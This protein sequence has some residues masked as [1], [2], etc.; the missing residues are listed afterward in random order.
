VAD[1]VVTKANNRFALRIQR[2]RQFGRA[3]AATKALLAAA[4][5]LGLF[6]A[7]E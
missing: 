3:S 5:L 7:I 1:R 6:E 4:A 2:S